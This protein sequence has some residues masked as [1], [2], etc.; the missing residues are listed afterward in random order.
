M[1]WLGA[2]LLGSGAAI[3]LAEW[4]KRAKILSFILLVGFRYPVGVSI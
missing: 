1:T 2:L 4:R 3:M